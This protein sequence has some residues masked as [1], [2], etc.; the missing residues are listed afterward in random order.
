MSKMFTRLFLL[1]LLVGSVRVFAT[2]G[3]VLINQS[4]V[5][6][7]GGFPFKITQAGSYKL[8]SNLQVPA[9]V[10]GIDIL[11]DHVT[12]DLNGFAI[13]GPVSCTLQPTVCPVAGSG[14][15]ISATCPSSLVN[16]TIVNNTGGTIQT[17]S[18]GCVL[19][20]NALR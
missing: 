8:S 13:I 5:L 15:G 7:A 18:A 16:N 19:A 6:A 11:A 1:F 12:L 10:D 9:S 2:D 3:V 17:D 14:V 4:S 20:N